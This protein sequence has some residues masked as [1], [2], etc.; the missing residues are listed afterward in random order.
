MKLKNPLL[1]LSVFTLFN[2]FSLNSYAVVDPFSMNSEVEKNEEST[3]KKLIKNIDKNLSV[4]DSFVQGGMNYTLYSGL[5]AFVGKSLSNDF[6]SEESSSRNL[7][8]D[9]SV[10]APKTILLDKGPFKIFFDSKA[11]RT[12]KNDRFLPNASNDLTAN[13]IESENTKS[14]FK[15]AFNNQTKKFAVVTRNAIVSVDSGKTIKVPKDFK[16]IRSYPEL[17]LYLVKVPENIK[18]KEAIAK[19]KSSNPKSLSVGEDR[20]AKVNVEVLENFKTAM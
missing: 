18:Y 14:V 16:I 13:N 17:G 2:V 6:I 9:L 3:E 15:V 19:L 10:S 12:T 4:E 11:V 5:K 8:Q 20:T 7:A 1:Y